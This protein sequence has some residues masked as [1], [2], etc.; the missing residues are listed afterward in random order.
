M[1]SGAQSSRNTDNVADYKQS[2]LC[3]AL[4]RAELRKDVECD[5]VC[6]RNASRQNA[7]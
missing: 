4:R 6:I 3:S 2:E 1:D 5:A 7:L